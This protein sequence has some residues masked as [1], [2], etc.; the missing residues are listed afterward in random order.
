MI[1]SRDKW[2]KQNTDK[3]ESSAQT[4]NYTTTWHNY[5]KTQQGIHKQTNQRLNTEH[6]DTTGKYTNDRMGGGDKTR[7][8]TTSHVK[9]KLDI[10]AEPNMIAVWEGDFL[11]E[12]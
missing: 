4:W 1:K 3:Q 8:K 10:N 7:I 9:S 11:T 12:D 5:T 6:L 2:N